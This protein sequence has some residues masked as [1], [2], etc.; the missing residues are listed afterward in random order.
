MSEYVGSSG[1]TVWEGLGFLVLLEEACHWEWAL[2]VQNSSLPP[3]CRSDVSSQPFLLPCLC[4]A[5]V[6]FIPQKAQIKY[7]LLC[8]TFALVSYRSNRK[9]TETILEEEKELNYD[10]QVTGCSRT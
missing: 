9:A 7:F 3:T 4:S 5:I 10:T 2:G 8:I 1:G 6:D